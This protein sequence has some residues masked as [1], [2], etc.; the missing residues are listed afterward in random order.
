[1]KHGGGLTK[2]P[3][4]KYSHRSIAWLETVHEGICR[5]EQ[6]YEQMKDNSVAF[7]SSLRQELAKSN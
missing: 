5:E 4:L 2:M 7:L 1:M 6:V 3:A